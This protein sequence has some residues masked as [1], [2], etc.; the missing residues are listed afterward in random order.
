MEGAALHRQGHGPAIR[1]AEGR[2]QEPLEPAGRHPGLSR[3][4]PHVTYGLV[5]RDGA[6]TLTLTHA[7]APPG[8]T[9]RTWSPTW[10]PVLADIKRVVE[11]GRP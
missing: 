5:E 8:T 1:A 3:E 7:T 9:P 4:L 2:E 10:A 6:M 11:E